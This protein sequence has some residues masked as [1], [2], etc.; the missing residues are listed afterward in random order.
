MAGQTTNIEGLDK[1]AVL[2]ALWHHSQPAPFFNAVPWAAPA[3][4]E[5]ELTEALSGQGRNDYYVDYLCG[6]VIKIDFGGDTI[7]GRNYD[8]DNGAGA[9]ARVVDGLRGK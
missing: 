2:R 6:R 8:R 5:A 1:K 9:A 3:L 4:S 7:N